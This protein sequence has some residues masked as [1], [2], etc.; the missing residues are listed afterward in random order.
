MLLHQFISSLNDAKHLLLAVSGGM[1]SV[2]LCELC[3]Q[4]KF[5]F[6]IAHCNFQL[7][8]EESERDEAFVKS[9]GKKY[10][11]EVFTKRFD[12]EAYASSNK[13][14]I[15]EAARELRYGWFNDILNGW[16]S[17]EKH[18]AWL[19]TAHHADDNAETLLMNFCRGTGLAGLK[20]IPASSGRIRRP[21]LSFSR[22]QISEFAREN[23]LEFVEDSSNE[24]VKYT[25]NHFR[26]EVIPAISKA[27]PSVKENLVHNAERFAE[28]E[29]LYRVAVD[30]IIVKLC[31]KKGN[32]VH[33][34]IK[35]LL[36]YENKAL[37][38]EIIS[39]YGFVEKQVEELI[40]LSSGESGRFIV[41][42]D[43]NYRIIHH[44]HWFIIS[45]AT[46]AEAENIIITEE[47]N[48][49]NYGTHQLRIQSI[50]PK[51][52]A[53]SMIRKGEAATTIAQL[54]A[55]LIEFPLLLRK[56]KEGDYFY[57]LGM[58]KKKKVARFLIDQR[59]SKSAKEN[60]WVIEMN[61]K[62]IWV[63]NHR[64]DDRFKITAN[65]KEILEI[66]SNPLP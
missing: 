43:G 51:G 52:N 40:K 12:T 44:R 23:S 55:R 17:K 61:R 3:H 24:S 15:Q 39:T 64:I 48:E 16:Q 53:L 33:I 13:L 42:P 6:T 47:N 50:T 9:L 38:F 19:L 63:V 56:W 26:N 4:A 7:R 37:I 58:R 54:D 46:S 60:V 5:D 1:D 29:R 30:G 31:K 22:A 45:P 32:E 34:P 36:G 65:T 2:V 25:R 10:A 35:Q 8:G 18:P 14:S 41:S 11:V 62:I 59:M 20:G 57:P 28:I 49:F 66:S 21:L 27:Y